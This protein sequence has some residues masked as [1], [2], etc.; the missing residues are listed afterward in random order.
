M[1]NSSEGYSLS[2]IAA[3]SGNRGGTFYE[4]NEGIH[5][6]HHGDYR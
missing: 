2:D 6:F 5:R 3:V 1:F 4:Q